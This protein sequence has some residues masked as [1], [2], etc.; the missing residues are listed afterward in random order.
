MW[1]RNM[2]RFI[3]SLTY[4]GRHQHYMNTMDKVLIF[5][6]ILI[7]AFTVSMIWLF[8][9]YMMVPDSL[10]VAV[11]AAVTGELGWMSMIQ[12]N[13]ERKQERQWQLEDE[14]RQREYMKED[15]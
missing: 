7:T 8:N 1:I 5:L 11:F 3:K 15:M 9:K 6:G 4:Q 13:K 14:K 10:I 12:K 2:E